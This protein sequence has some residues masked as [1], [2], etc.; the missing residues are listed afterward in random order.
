MLFRSEISNFIH[1][2]AHP[3]GKAPSG[4][5][6]TISI[7]ADIRGFFSLADSNIVEFVA[8]GKSIS[9]NKYQYHI[10]EVERKLKQLEQYDSVMT[11]ENKLRIESFF[12]YFVRYKALVVVASKIR[13]SPRW[14]RGLYRIKNELIP[15]S[16]NIFNSLSVI[17]S[18]INQQVVYESKKL[19]FIS[20]AVLLGLFI[21]L[22]FL[23]WLS[24]YLARRKALE[25]SQPLIELD[26]AAHKIADEQI[27]SDIQIDGADELQRLADSFNYMY[28][29]L[30]RHKQELISNN[31]KLVAA[32]NSKNDFLSSVSHEFRTPLNAIIGYSELMTMEVAKGSSKT[33]NISNIKQIYDAGHA[34]LELVEASLNMANLDDIQIN[35]KSVSVEDLLNEIHKKNNT[36]AESL[37]INFSVDKISNADVKIPV[38]ANILTR[39]LNCYLDNTFKFSPENSTVNI[40]YEFIG[41]EK[42]RIKVNDNGPGLPKE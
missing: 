4:T 2:I 18:R 30:Y 7:A 23:L 36:K 20:N 9:I 42:L 32:N 15:L 31:L 22:I 25:I 11:E 8:F 5:I 14:N 37:K 17:D 27:D 34:M 40:S 6:K 38:D 29:K 3:E 28:R 19:V 10:E 1:T 21:S 16:G 41:E 33:V 12:R 26:H 24:V 13:K 35:I 39:I